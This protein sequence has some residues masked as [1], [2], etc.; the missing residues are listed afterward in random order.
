MTQQPYPNQPVQS[1]PPPAPPGGY[2]YYGPGI[3]REPVWPK[4]I[5]TISIV[6]GGLF[7]LGTFWPLVKK[8]DFRQFQPEVRQ[9]LEDWTRTWQ[10]LG[11]IVGLGTNG[12]LLAGGIFLLKRRRAARALHLAYAVLTFLASL[13]AIYPMALASKGIVLPPNS[14]PM[15]HSAAR[16]AMIAVLIVTLAITWAYPTFLLIWFSRRK[17]LADLA[18]W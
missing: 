9:Q 10:P 11:V 18:A 4:A 7:L 15:A 16:A 14:P 6:L 12:A 13:Q 17:V 2:G 1:P 8:T 5:G 3:P